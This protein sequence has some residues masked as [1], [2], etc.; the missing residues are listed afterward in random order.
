MKVNK[1]EWLRM[2]HEYP[3]KKSAKH[4]SEK[5]KIIDELAGRGL[6]KNSKQD[7]EKAIW[8]LQRYLEKA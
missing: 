3:F 1:E 5:D 7:I 8:H 4:N 6:E 2:S